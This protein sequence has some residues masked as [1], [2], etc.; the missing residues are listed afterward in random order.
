MANLTLKVC[1]LEGDIYD[2]DAYRRQKQQ[3]NNSIKIKD[4]FDFF[5]SNVDIPEFDIPE[6]EITDF[7]DDFDKPQ[8]RRR[9]KIDIA[10]DKFTPPYILAHLAED[11]NIRIRVNVAANSATPLHV[12]KQLTEDKD[13]EVRETAMR[14][15]QELGLL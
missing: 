13:E 1:L 14:T 11:E 6:Y 12:L 4:L 7:D 2:L 3:K 5:D 15:L 9:S 8:S 10:I